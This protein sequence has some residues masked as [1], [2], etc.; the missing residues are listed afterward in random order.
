MVEELNLQ[1][2]KELGLSQDESVRI[3]PNLYQA[4]FE[5]AFG[6]GLFYSHKKSL[7]WLKGQSFAFDNVMPFL[8]KESFQAQSF[9]LLSFRNQFP[10]GQAWVTSL[11]KDTNFVLRNEDQPL[12][13]E[14]FDL[15]DVDSFLSDK[16][17]FSFVVSHQSFKFKKPK[18]YPFSAWICD[19][20]PHFCV[21]IFGSK[22][23]TPVQTAKFFT[24]DV[25]AVLNTIKNESQSRADQKIVEKFEAQ[26]P[27]NFY[28]YFASGQTRIYNRSL[29]YNENL[30]AN[31]LKAALI[32]SLNLTDKN[33]IIDF[34]QC[35]HPQLDI[36]WWE[37]KP[38]EAMRRGLI[39]LPLE[40]IAR[41]GIHKEIE[42]A[43][44]ECQI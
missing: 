25:D 4:V 2:H 12:T 19:Y 35:S 33:S 13:G 34:N 27:P 1:I 28:P 17:I 14:T 22:F 44:K 10:D 6:T 8:Y 29:I 24:Y 9:S 16:K 42:D 43:V 23:K 36:S 15:S 32:R 39:A 21:A 37:N 26:L 11:S 41:S 5:I 3:Y 40:V 38:R 7:A 30:N 18:I 31:A 20:G